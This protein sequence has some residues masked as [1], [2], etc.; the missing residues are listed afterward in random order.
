MPSN[1]TTL[2]TKLEVGSFRQVGADG[3]TYEIK[4]YHDQIADIY[5]YH[6]QICQY[7]V[8]PPQRICKRLSG[9]DCL[10]SELP[11]GAN[12]YRRDSE[13]LSLNIFIIASRQEMKLLFVMA[14]A[15]NVFNAIISVI[16]W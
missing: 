1:Q 15:A 16:V 5:I 11:Y 10:Q 12:P 9:G 7:A 4:V 2:N 3:F 8:R 6:P 14:V 13:G